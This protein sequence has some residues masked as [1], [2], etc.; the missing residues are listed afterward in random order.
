[1]NNVSGEEKEK[2][3]DENLRGENSPFHKAYV[4]NPEKY[5]GK[6]H[7]SFGL[8][9]NKNANSKK[10]VVVFPNGDEYIVVGMNHFCRTCKCYELRG[11]NMIQCANKLII[12]RGLNAD[13]TQK[14]TQILK[15]G[16]LNLMRIIIQACMKIN[17]YLKLYINF[18]TKMEERLLLESLI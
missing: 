12:T 2:W 11:P 8:V 16:I 5:K 1:M 10:Y 17:T 4:K 15:F 3:L 18:I 9:G 7:P 14:K 6:N 13:I